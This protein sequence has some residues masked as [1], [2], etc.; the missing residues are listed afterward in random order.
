MNGVSFAQPT[1]PRPSN[2]PKDITLR[3]LLR[4]DDDQS[5]PC[6]LFWCYFVTYSKLNKGG[7]S[8]VPNI[9]GVFS[10]SGETND[11]NFDKLFGDLAFGYFVGLLNKVTFTVTDTNSGTTTK[12]QLDI[13][14]PTTTNPTGAPPPPIDFRTGIK[15]CSLVQI[16]NLVQSYS[17][18]ATNLST[19]KRYGPYKLGP[20][21]S[22]DSHTNNELNQPI[23]D[24]ALDCVISYLSLFDCQIAAAS[25]P[26]VPA[27]PPA[28]GPP[29][30][31]PP[32]GIIACYGNK[33]HAF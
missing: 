11:P 33:V 28:G 3:D 5:K 15:F 12:Y 26:G 32:P 31:P 19:N 20:R 4:K 10:V 18:T 13:V 23:G 7:K 1:P 9:K 6:G 2:K 29:P 16:S 25:G 24:M 17:V 8:E 30:P 27:P 14:G 21:P 22:S